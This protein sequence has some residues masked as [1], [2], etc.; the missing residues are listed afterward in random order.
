MKALRLRLLLHTHVHTRARKRLR[1]S[2]RN[3][4]GSNAKEKCGAKARKGK[5]G[6]VIFGVGVRNGEDGGASF[7]TR[8]DIHQSR[9]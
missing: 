7:S 6:K 5:W 4:A 8:R 3:V 2:G 1:G 9:T